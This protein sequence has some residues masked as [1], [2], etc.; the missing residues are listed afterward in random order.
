MVRPMLVQPARMM[1]HMT[2]LVSFL[3]EFA[4]ITS[5]HFE[6][7]AREVKNYAKEIIPSFEDWFHYNARHNPFGVAVKFFEDLFN[8]NV[9]DETGKLVET[10]DLIKKAEHGERAMVEHP[11]ILITDCP[12]E[13][14]PQ[15][16]VE[17]NAIYK[18]L[19]LCETLPMP[20]G[21]EDGNEYKLEF[22]TLGG[23]V[24]TMKICQSETEPWHIEVYES[25]CSA[26]SYYYWETRK[27]QDGIAHFSV[28][29]GEWFK[30]LGGHEP[31]AERIEY[32]D[33][34]VLYQKKHLGACLSRTVFDV[35]CINSDGA[36][37][38]KN[39]FSVRLY[40][41]VN[42]RGDYIF[43]SKKKKWIWTGDVS[44]RY[45]VTLSPE[46]WGWN[47][48]ITVQF[49]GLK[50]EEK[51][52]FSLVSGFDV[53]SIKIVEPRTKNLIT[54]ECLTIPEGDVV[55]SVVRS[56]R[57]AERGFDE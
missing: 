4:K 38:F 51:L 48:R 15:V 14:R 43:D 57:E 33:G 5:E 26:K 21:L 44:H 45:K 18:Y 11:T 50:P 39:M 31:D 7:T 3:T 2:L 6:K 30:S 55:L 20:D 23:D 16:I 42:D 12:I 52:E 29:A 1:T 53:G 49:C 28:K 10:I 40:A 54:F 27:A 8:H 36:E 37:K 41:L 13:E 22:E 9:F 25:N 46:R 34:T 47:N 17:K 32:E 19:K 35:K 24:V 56:S